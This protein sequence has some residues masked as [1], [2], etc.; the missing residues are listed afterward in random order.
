MLNEL[1]V[2]LVICTALY[3]LSTNDNNK[4]NVQILPTF[5][6]GRALSPLLA[7]LPVVIVTLRRVVTSDVDVTGA[8][9]TLDGR[10]V[11]TSRVRFISRCSAVCC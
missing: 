10:T 3:K 7:D 6:G 1:R 8:D 11:A 4:N 2:Y 9:L 5:A